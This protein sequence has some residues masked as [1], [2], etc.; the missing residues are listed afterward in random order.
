MKTFGQHFQS[1]DWKGEKHVPIIHAPDK[2]RA[3]ENFELKVSV[4]DD[5][6]HPN[7]LEHYIAWAKVYFIQEA[8]KF[9]VELGDFRFTAH[10]EGGNFTEPLA[11][12]KVNLEE[13]GTIY[14]ISY[15]NIH[16]LWE[17]SKK[18]IVE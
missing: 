5:I 6:P 11:L 16:G 10:G 12:M 4:G 13:S 17:N 8:G 14:A 15:C 1:G 3:G 2:V 18:I 9:P 7:S